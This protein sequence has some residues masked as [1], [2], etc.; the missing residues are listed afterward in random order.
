MFGDVTVLLP[1][2]VRLRGFMLC[3]AV[4]CCADVL[5]L[6]GVLLI[7]AVVA[8]VFRSVVVAVLLP[9]L[10]ARSLYHPPHR[11]LAALTAFTKYT[12]GPL[13]IPTT[14][15]APA[16]AADSAKGG[17][18]DVETPLVAEE[19][20]EQSVSDLFELFV[21]QLPPHFGSS[22]TSLS[23]MPPPHAV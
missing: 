8:A 10:C 12:A 14:A 20:I 23:A 22:F 6:T 11:L 13:D 4:C 5:L 3:A 15:R 19:A 18:T 21:R 1:R 9:R 16:A 2:L 7:A 17:D